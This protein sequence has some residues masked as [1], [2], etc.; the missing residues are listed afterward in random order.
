[1]HKH[2]LIEQYL[3]DQINSG[4]LQPGQQMETEEALALRFG[5]SRPTVRQAVNKLALEGYLQRVKG[6]GTFFVQPKLMHTSTSFIASYRREAVE[7]GYDIRTQVLVLRTL[8]ADEF[9][10]SRLGLKVKSKVTQLSRLRWVNSKT[11]GRPVV[12]TMVYVPQ[13]LFP[14]MPSL[15]FTNV[16]LYDTL[17][18]RG[19]KVSHVSRIL[20]VVPPSDTVCE[21][22]KLAPWEPAIFISSQGFLENGVAI[23][24][25]ESWYPASSSKF[26]IELE[27]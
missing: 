21:F 2:T 11:N 22:L 15:D 1:M 5:V 19:L 8:H 16:S 3:L 12:Y 24:Y 14:E 10:A 4:S 7:Q 25:A 6:K 13:K 23:E 17:E 20:E 26:L 18:K 27:G 9:L